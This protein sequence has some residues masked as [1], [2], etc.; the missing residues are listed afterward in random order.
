[1]TD[2]QLPNRIIA[3][4]EEALGERVNVYHKMKTLS[5]II[6]AMDDEERVWIRSTG[7]GNLMDFPDKPAWS[8]SFGLFLLS[9]QLEVARA[10]EIW[11]VFAGTPVRFSLREFKIV[12]GLQCGRF[13][14]MQ[15]RKRKGTAG[16]KIPYYSTLF[17]LEEDVTVDR[18]ISMLKKRHVTDKEIRKR[19]VCLA[20]VDGFLVPT[21]HYPKIVKEHAEM[22]EDLQFFLSYPWGRLS[23]EMM[24]KSIKDR[25]VVQLA[26][27]SAPAIQE[28]SPSHE[29]PCSDSDE[30][31]A[32]DAG[33]R[34]SV[35][36]KIS[37][38]KRLDS[39][40]EILVDPI[41]SPDLEMDTD[42]DLTWDDDCADVAVDN[43]VSLAE[44][45]FLFN[46]D[47]FTG[48]CIPSQLE[49]APKKQ[50]RGVKAKITRARKAQK[51][52]SS[53]AGMN[54]DR[55]TA[56]QAPSGVSGMCNLATLSRLLDSKL[57]AMEARIIKGVTDLITTNAN[58]VFP[59]HSDVLDSGLS[60]HQRTNSP[61]PTSPKQPSKGI[62]R[63]ETSPEIV[64]EDTNR[65]TP[66]HSIAETDVVY[67][68]RAAAMNSIAAVL[69]CYQ[70][71]SNAP[72]IAQTAPK[73]P[74]V[75]PDA[76]AETI[77]PVNKD[78]EVGGGCVLNGCDGR[79]ETQPLGLVVGDGVGFTS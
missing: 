11:V 21:S 32:A 30:E 71:N 29:H 1:M 43:I 78:S 64:V 74:A 42:E 55:G 6:D 4:G 54:R 16:I 49:L 2:L 68:N 34:H 44:E 19:F 52:S 14:N 25:D 72:N 10:H 60:D 26:T 5:L 8:A 61:T 36:L 73:N 27:T 35:P 48:G 38:A 51:P 75:T 17:G 9:R 65:P 56:V 24:M 23:F 7:F 45:G 41:I 28:G 77:L 66:I 40:C 76:G 3:Y 63:L 59:K 69:S 20:I 50:K 79:I 18:V 15:K 67:T 46:N 47:M 58:R 57:A 39:N 62:H 37:N 31:P 12:T 13:P 70:D 33:T 53:Q 22:C